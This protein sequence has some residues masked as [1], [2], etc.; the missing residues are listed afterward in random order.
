[1]HGSYTRYIMETTRQRFEQA[2][3]NGRWAANNGKP[4]EVPE[5]YRDR[6]AAWLVGYDKANNGQ[7]VA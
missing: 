1:M 3:F 2:E 5:E 6:A 7:E 4:R